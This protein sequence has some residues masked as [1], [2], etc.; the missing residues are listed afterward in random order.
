MTTQLPKFRN[1]LEIIP[2]VVEGEG[3]R[4]II[5]DLQSDRTFAFGEEEYF[6]CRQLD[7]QTPLPVIQDSFYQQFHISIELVQLEA[8]VRQLATMELLEYAL[9]PE[10]IPWHFPL[11][12]KKHILGN[13]DHFLQQVSSLFSWCF[14]RSFVVV[15]GLLVLM[16][17]L[18]F[19]KY[20]YFYHY[21]V[22]NTLWYPGPFFLETLIGLFV[23]NVS[24]E[25]G[26]AFALKHW[27][28]NIPEV[29][30]GLAYRL[31]PTFHFDI[32][33]LWT[34]KKAVQLKVL[35]AGL[36]G[37]LLL[38]AVGM[39]GWR[40]STSGTDM[41]TFWIIFSVAAQFFFLINLIPLLPR[42]GYYLL[43]AWLEIP[44]LFYRSRSLVEAWFFRRPLPEPVTSRQRLWY[45]VFGGF[46]IVFLFSFWLLVLGILGYCLIWYWKLKGLGACL[47]LLILGLRYGDA[48]K[49]LAH[50]LFSPRN[51]M[52]NQEG[53]INK[54]LLFKMGLLVALIIIFLIPYPFD[55]GGDFKILPVNQLSVRAMVQGEIE[56]VMVKEGQWVK[57]G[58][59]LALLADKDQKA[60]RDSAKESLT[61][62]QEKLTM[63]RN[64]PKPEAVAKAEQ[65]VKL[66]AKA[67]QY[68]T[69]EADRYTK[70]FREK[71][72]SEKEY[73]DY[74]KARDEDR[75][76]LILAKKNLELV[77]VPFRPEEIKQMEAEVRR[78][79]AELVLAEKNL[80]L[81]K[82]LS[83]AEGRLITAYPLQ[84]V[85]QYLDV[86]ELLG[87]LQDAR[88]TI[89]EIEVPESDIAQVKLGAPVNLKT[90]ALPT[91]TFKGK[92]TKIAPVGFT[93]ERG[94]VEKGLTE[95]EFRTMQVIQESDKVIRVLSEFPDTHGLLRTDMTGYAKIRGSWMPLGVAFTRWLMRLLLVEV[96]SWIP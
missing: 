31:I 48:M 35:S 13:P 78:L 28:G 53:S 8:F 45:K 20:F 30:V 73:M 27:G 36:A 29:C 96:W 3:L 90:W 21:E 80:Q 23:I 40:V 6:I 91:K 72:V 64:G 95:R 17:I 46:S 1:N 68:S 7:G 87:V 74:L 76:R 60:R 77:K 12:Y 92:V 55:A 2:R 63:M 43:A 71:S 34:E 56:Q 41:H 88:V 5:N 9:K 67:L 61:A 54:K 84:K 33:D 50:K 24:G 83:P 32:S 65:E 10:E 11:Y 38:V 14:S 16:S 66:V 4:Y 86:G 49:Q 51:V 37:Q 75:E 19:L 70:M 93:Q 62:A 25:F 57:K 79:E 94:R 85:G 69:V 18:L 89:A 15:W 52:V 59:I 26:K 22:K 44:D 47:F 39:L 58:Q 81:T 42:D 82:L